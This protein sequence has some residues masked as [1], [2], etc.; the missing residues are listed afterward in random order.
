MVCFNSLRRFVEGIAYIFLF[1]PQV[2]S[3]FFIV[4]AEKDKF[5]TALT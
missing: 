4:K 5:Q 1:T 3:D 2:E